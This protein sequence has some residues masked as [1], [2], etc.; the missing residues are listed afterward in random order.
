MFVDDTT[1]FQFGKRTH[2]LLSSKMKP[3]CDWFSSSKLTFNPT[4]YEAMCFGRSQPEKIK[5]GPADMDHKSF[6]KYMR[7]HLDKKLTF[8]EQMDYVAKK[9]NRFLKS[10]K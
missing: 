5:I 6:C 9:I 2:C 7:V 3:V 8:R 1:L 10:F 4:K